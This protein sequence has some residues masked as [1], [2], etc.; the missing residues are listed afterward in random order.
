MA[1]KPDSFLIME[2]PLLNNIDEEA[3]TILKVT[4]NYVTLL[5][6][7]ILKASILSFKDLFLCSV[8]EITAETTQRIVSLI[9]KFK[10]TMELYYIV[11]N[12]A[13]KMDVFL[14]VET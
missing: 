1:K 11:S 5:V 14:N 4:C 10:V 7:S 12:S 13:L 3:L 9:A 6:N 2:N 8:E